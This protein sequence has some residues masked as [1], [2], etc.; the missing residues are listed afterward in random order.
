MTSYEDLPEDVQDDEYRRCAASASGRDFRKDLDKALLEYMYAEGRI[1]RPGPALRQDGTV[2][3]LPSDVINN[4]IVDHMG[5]DVRRAQ[6]HAK[7][8]GRRARQAGRLPP[9]VPNAK[10]RKAKMDK[11]KEEARL[12]EEEKATN[13]HVPGHELDTVSYTHLRAHETGA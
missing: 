6:V 2:A 7:G 3:D 1:A 11:E 12:Q 4:C 5:D 10:E 9:F 13:T 8:A